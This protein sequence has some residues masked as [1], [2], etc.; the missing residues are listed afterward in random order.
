MKSHKK[1]PSPLEIKIFK[2]NNRIKLLFITKKL[3]KK[4]NVAQP[5][6]SREILK[7]DIKNSAQFPPLFF[8]RRIERISPENER[9]EKIFVIQSGVK[10]MIDI[11][12]VDSSSF[13]FAKNYVNTFSSQDP[14]FLTPLT[15]SWHLRETH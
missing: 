11:K 15:K 12:K 7:Q 10:G 8:T 2:F 14:E 4:E 3:R 9:R 1:F 5:N 6:D 13:L